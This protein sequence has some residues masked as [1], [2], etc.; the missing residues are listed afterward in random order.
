MLTE[1]ERRL[2]SVNSHHSFSSEGV[3]P[4]T[5]IDTQMLLLFLFVFINRY[6]KDTAQEVQNI[7][8][9]RCDKG[10]LLIFFVYKY[11]IEKLYKKN[12]NLF[13]YENYYSMCE[14][15]FQKTV[16]FI[17]YV[18][19]V[20]VRTKIIFCFCFKNYQTYKE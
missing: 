9:S 1:K 16:E 8:F 4:F 11:N 20:N 13:S 19:N 18:N 17:F 7:S 3:I 6:A 5:R 2:H 10:V 14:N 12:S 15:M